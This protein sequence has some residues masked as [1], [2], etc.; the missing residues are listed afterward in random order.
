MCPP[1]KKCLMSFFGHCACSGTKQ[2]T[3]SAVIELIWRKYSFKNIDH[4][5]NILKGLHDEFS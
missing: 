1:H 2:I 3:C 4:E 5:K